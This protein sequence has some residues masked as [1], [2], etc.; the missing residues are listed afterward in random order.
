[1]KIHEVFQHKTVLSFEVF[2]PKKSTSIVS[3]YN[4]LDDLKDLAPDF[5]SVTFGAG[6]SVSQQTTIPIAKTIQ[7]ENGVPS[8]AH[9]PSIH[10]S[11]NDVL[12]LLDKLKQAGIENI[13]ALRGDLPT[14]VPIK[15]DFKYARDLVSFI[16]EQGDFSIL[17]ACYPESH[18]ESQNIVADILHLKDKVNAG[19]DQLVSQLFFDNTLFYQFLERCHIAGIDVP[20]EAGIMPVVNK[21]QIERIVK[22]SK[23]T[24][25]T[26]FIR[27]MERYEHCP[28][29][30]RDAG[31]AYAVNQIVD[32]VSEG[33]DGIHLYTM[34]NPLVAKRICQA[35][36]TLFKDSIRPLQ[37]T[38]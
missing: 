32:L 35:T 17:S 30:M 37:A 6:G 34:N 28:E 3:I 7:R 27:M 31:I 5:I 15:Q 18:A 33:V 38:G 36:Q 14:D 20:I 16:K 19:V 8:V 12:Q 24:L 9:L 25:P 2:P 13:L 1:M 29:A 4:T 23:V 10:L 22:L 26:K 11:K 21:R